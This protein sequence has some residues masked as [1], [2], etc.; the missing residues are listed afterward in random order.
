[1]P[2]Q[3]QAMLAAPGLT[4]TQQ[5]AIGELAG[6]LASGTKQPIYDAL[7]NEVSADSHADDIAAAKFQKEIIAARKKAIEKRLR[8][9]KK[10]LQEALSPKEQS[11][12]L[13]EQGRLIGEL[14]SAKTT[15]AGLNET[16][17]QA[18][19][20]PANPPPTAMDYMN[21][22]LAL[23]EL[24][25]DLA[26]D[27]AVRER[28]LKVAEEQLT[29]ALATADPRDDIEAAQQVKALREAVNGLNEVLQQREAFEKERLEVDKRLMHLAESQGPALFAAVLSWVD[30][31]I[32]GP[33]QNRDRLATAG[34]SAAY[35]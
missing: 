3:I 16:I 6:T 11:R 28:M 12:L 20:E 31:A 25:P 33:L 23:A 1:L 7:G 5:L 34:S 14:G 13:A 8:Q 18:P 24:T 30:G 32:G 22:D 27:R 9:I 15:L 35:Q 17:N 21:R 10:R 29:A 4:K 26:D 2:A 19:D